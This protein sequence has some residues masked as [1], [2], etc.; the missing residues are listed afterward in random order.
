MLYIVCMDFKDEI[1]GLLDDGRTTLVFPTENAARWWLSRYVRERRCSILAS[2]AVAFD[3]FKS[4]FSPSQEKRPSNRFYRLAFV[5]SFL[6]GGGTGMQYLYDDTLSEY[7]NRF[8]PFMV[9]IIPSLRDLDCVYIDNRKLRSDLTILKTAYTTFLERHGL[10]EPLWQKPSVENARNLGGRYALI[11]YDADI[12]MQA[13]MRDLGDVDF[14]TKVSL[15]CSKTP[16]YFKYFTVEAELE[17]LFRRLQELKHQH[18][19]TEDIIISTPDFDSLQPYLERKSRE[20]NTPL[21]FMRSLKLTETVPGRYLFSVRRCIRENL[22]FNSLEALL[23]DTALPYRNI[24]TNR[25]LIRF[26]IDHNH[27]SGS[28]SFEGDELFRDLAK[29]ARKKGD[30]SMLA[31]Y[32]DLKSALSAIRTARSGDEL[33]RDIHGLTA[34]LL[35]NDEFSLSDP[36][37][38]DV[39]SFMFSNLAEISTTLKECSLTL[40]NLFSIFMGEVENLSYVAQEKKNGIRVYDYGQDHLLDAPHHFLISLN[41]S[42]ATVSQTELGF[43]EDHEV[44]RRNVIDV[45]DRLLAYYQSVSADAWIS[46]SETSYSGSQSTPTFFVKQNAVKDMTLEDSG[47]VFEKADRD[48]LAQGQKTFLQPKGPDLAVDRFGRPVDPDTVRLSYT[49]I[50]GYAR[51]PYAEYLRKDITKDAPDDFEP[52]KQDD[53]QIGSFLHEVIQ[54]FMAKHMGELLEEPMLDSYHREIEEILDRKLSENRVFDF[55]TK[56]SIRGRYLESLQNV[57]SLLLIPS[58]KKS[59]IGSFFPIRNE[60]SL[61]HNSHFTGSIDTVIEDRDGQTYLLDYKKG[62]GEATYQL[63]LYKRL[64]EEAFPDKN[65]R[66][67]FFFSMRDGTFN[68]FNDA[69]W[70]KQEQKLDHDIALIREGYTAGNWIATPSKDACQ[71]CRERSVCRR[72]FNLQ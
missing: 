41:D 29:D 14:I 54:A 23:L 17:A 16:Q 30:E 3:R 27:L 25:K 2:R 45:T 32:R 20:Y 62:D 7:H 37:D 33:I 8:V 64:F 71:L 65:V 39:Y 56:A 66:D 57:V 47:P 13:L 15:K 1:F 11:G 5:S 63:V 60:Q 69:K 18:V 21:S 9:G 36:M 31:L 46:G 59:Y 34:M 42:N 28:L 19:P 67:C 53:R 72:R 35:G 55:Y 51:C 12:Q 22:S 38:K 4:L 43:L 48:S 61:N 6:E 40:G 52:S 49:S 58:R 24:D 44:Q 26:M 68:G 70:E 50:S 10:Y